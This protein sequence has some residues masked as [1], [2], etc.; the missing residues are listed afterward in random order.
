M[1]K[2]SISW[3]IFDKKAI[4]SAN[5]I[6]ATQVRIANIVKEIPE[7]DYR[8]PLIYLDGENIEIG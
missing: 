8:I 7:N 5:S 4:I 6:D 1:I 3:K 2:V